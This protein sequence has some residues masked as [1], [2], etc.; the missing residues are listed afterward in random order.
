[1]E[2][3]STLVHSNPNPIDN[4]GP[5]LRIVTITLLVLAVTSF[6]MRTYVRV[7][8]VKSFGLDDCLMTLATAAFV[9]YSSCVLAGVYY[10][11][12]RHLADLSDSDARQ[13]EQ[14]RTGITTC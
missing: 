8:M 11:T 3:T 13:A 5:L 2:A 9:L 14:V 12:G 7:C 10:G 6:S 4:R 1:M